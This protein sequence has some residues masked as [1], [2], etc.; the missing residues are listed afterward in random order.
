MS[1][2]KIPRR[3]TV[4][5]QHLIKDLRNTIDECRV[6]LN[7]VST[8]L[9]NEANISSYEVFSVLMTELCK[10]RSLTNNLVDGVCS[11]MDDPE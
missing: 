2:K 9:E 3:V 5:V 6:D 10:V 7:C 11:N 4:S 1:T 8:L